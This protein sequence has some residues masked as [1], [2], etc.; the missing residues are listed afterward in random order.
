MCMQAELFTK[1]QLPVKSNKTE[2]G[3]LLVQF[4]EIINM[5]RTCNKYKPITIARVGMLVSHI[6]TKDLYYLLSV[7]KDAGTRAKR[8]DEGFAKMFYWSIKV[9]DEKKTIN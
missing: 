3:E 7:C 2:R 1:Y 8:Y 4:L 6:P 9:Q 5:S